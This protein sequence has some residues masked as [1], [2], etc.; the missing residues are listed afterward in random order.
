MYC[1]VIL[2]FPETLV[3]AHLAPFSSRDSISRSFSRRSGACDIPSQRVRARRIPRIHYA[4]FK[5]YHYQI[6]TKKRHVKK[7]ILLLRSIRF[8]YIFFRPVFAN[9]KSI[10]SN[11]VLLDNLHHL[12]HKS[13]DQD[14]NRYAH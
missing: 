9:P 10:Q 11:I 13:S 5:V 12:M 4:G 3:S 14:V 7:I 6:F 1:D 8:Y 2:C